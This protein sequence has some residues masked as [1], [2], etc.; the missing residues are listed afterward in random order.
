MVRHQQSPAGRRERFQTPYFW[1]EP[2]VD[3]GRDRV[4]QQLGEGRIPLSHLRRVDIVGAQVF[5]SAVFEWGTSIG[6]PSACNA[7]MRRHMP[8]VSA[9]CHAPTAID[10]SAE[11]QSPA[12]WG[13][14]TSVTHTGG[15]R[16]GLIRGL[17]AAMA[18]QKTRL[19]NPRQR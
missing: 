8:V 16:P 14:K 4:D 18:G 3:Y 13:P 11:P 1:P 12:W 7:V 10:V 9:C 6:N 15:R 5:P 17:M 2:P 19:N